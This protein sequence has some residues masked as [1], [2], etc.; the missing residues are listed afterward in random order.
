MQSLEE[1]EGRKL[2][3]ALKSYNVSAVLEHCKVICILIQMHLNLSFYIK[4]LV[5]FPN[6]IF[7]NKANLLSYWI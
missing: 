4:D 5:F 7:D 2:K 3:I 6:C 1:I